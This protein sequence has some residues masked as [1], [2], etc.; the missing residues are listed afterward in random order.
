[1]NSEVEFRNLALHHC[2]TERLGTAMAE[3]IKAI[4]ES[5]PLELSVAEFLAQLRRLGAAAKAFDAHQ[6]PE[7]YADPFEPVD[8]VISAAETV[9]RDSA[10]LPPG[11]VGCVW[12]LVEA[13][14]M[15]RQ[16]LA[17]LPGESS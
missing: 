8:G 12:V 6:W 15:L 5:D 3:G 13:I 17:A 11:P 2:S 14:E 1:M 9:V 16:A 4:A 10:Q 7:D